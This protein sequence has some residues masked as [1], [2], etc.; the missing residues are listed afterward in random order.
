MYPSIDSLNIHLYYKKCRNKVKFIH[1]CSY[2]F[3]KIPLARV[4]F[5]VAFKLG[6]V[7]GDLGAKLARYLFDGADKLLS[8]ALA[9]VPGVN[10]VIFKDKFIVLFAAVRHEV[11]VL[12]L[13]AVKVPRDIALAH[14][15]ALY[16]WRVFTAFGVKISPKFF[17]FTGHYRFS[18]LPHQI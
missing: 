4:D 7:L 5:L 6:G 18:H 16:T 15:F 13:L 1:F 2:K 14:R 12:A 9:A 10:F 17:K 3:S 11:D 8:T